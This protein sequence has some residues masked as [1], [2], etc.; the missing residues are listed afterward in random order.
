MPETPAKKVT[1]AKKASPKPK[2]GYTFA[3]GSSTYNVR[4]NIT[5]IRRGQVWYSDD[6]VVKAFP[7]M[8]G[9]PPIVTSSVPR[10]SAGRQK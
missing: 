10:D 4:G 7:E 9:A 6:P 8:F 1:R 3:L 5:R 2:P